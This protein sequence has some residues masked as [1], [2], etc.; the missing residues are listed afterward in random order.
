M[1]GIFLLNH[2]LDAL[3]LICAL[4][5]CWKLARGYGIRRAFW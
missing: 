4:S 3:G 5:V 2:V 1:I